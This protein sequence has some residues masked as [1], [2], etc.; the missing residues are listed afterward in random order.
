MSGK[1]K[2]HKAIQ[3]RI[4]LTASGKVKRRKVGL[5]HLCS[6][7]SGARKRKL[8]RPAIAPA[9]EQKRVHQMLG[10]R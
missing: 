8:R 7:K 6:H 4:R 5:G 3:K 10:L 9:M 1:F 2:P